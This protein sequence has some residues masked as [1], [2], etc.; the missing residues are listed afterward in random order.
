VQLDSTGDFG[1]SV[2]VART[3]SA[4][5]SERS[6]WRYWNGTGWTSDKRLPAAGRLISKQADTVVSVWCSGRTWNLVSQK[7][8]MLGRDIALWTATAPQGP[9]RDAGV[10]YTIPASGHPDALYYE[11]TAHPEVRLA[12]GKL[13]LSYSR[14][15]SRQH[16]CTDANWYKPQYVEVSINGGSRTFASADWPNGAI[17]WCRRAY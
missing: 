17:G 2:Y 5:A 11:S 6:R 14:N 12:S 4:K 10:L 7:Y 15:G 3:S 8:G 13:L 1:R 16:I 9:W